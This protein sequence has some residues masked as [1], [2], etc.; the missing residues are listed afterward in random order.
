MKENLKLIA[1]ITA[2]TSLKWLMIVIM[3]TLLTL[4]FFS[5]VLFQSTGY[6]DT[7]MGHAGEASVY[8]ILVN[9]FSRNICAFILLVGAP[10]FTFLYLMIANKYAVQ[11]TIYQIWQ[12]KLGSVIEAKV[13]TL[14]DFIIAKNNTAGGISDAAALKLKVLDANRTSPDTSKIQK[15]AI[16]Y[17]FN[18]IQL[19]DVDFKKEDLK[20]SDIV[21]MKL[22]NIV[23]ELAEPSL[24]FFWILFGLQIVLFVVS[25]FY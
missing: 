7:R 1:K 25:Q 6:T 9:M 3:G 13:V 8:L 23:A 12:N 5:I 21:G 22:N 24:L 2:K 16:A 19:D 10:V 14:V 4:I 18:K 11:Y 17:L 20:L 15:K